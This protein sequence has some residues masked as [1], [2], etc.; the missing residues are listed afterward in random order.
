MRPLL[1]LLSLAVAACAGSMA[2]SASSAGSSASGTAAA[3]RLP[4]LDSAR[5]LGDLFRLAH[6]SMGGRAAMTPQN[7]K[8]RAFLVGELRRIGLEPVNGSYEHAFV[9]PR[10]NNTD[11]VRGVNVLGL[12]PGTVDPERVI[13]VSAHYDHVGT[14]NGEIYNGADDNASGTAAV[15]QIAAALK[16]APP[17]HSVIIA[18]FDAEEMGLVGARAFVAKPPVELSRIAA[19][20]NLDM[21]SRNDRNELWAAGASPYPQMRPLL[22]AVARVA[23]VQLKLGHDSGGGREDWTN[24]SDQG[25]FNA[26]KIPFVYFGVEDH[27]DY[28]KPSDDPEKVDGGF[29]LRSARTIAAF[30]RHLD[31]NLPAR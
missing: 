2:S 14:R 1:A 11:S 21:V 19:N 8:A 9:M 29:Y 12:V 24:Q 18:L 25:A 30:V 15:L 5:L 27:P 3:V 4:T 22:E 10:R 31:E 17:R 28:H 16:A 23:P 20:V 13:V 6:D 7:A 26:A